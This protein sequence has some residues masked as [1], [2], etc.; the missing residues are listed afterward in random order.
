[1]G[2]T[3][4]GAGADDEGAEA[5]DAVA[6]G[7]LVMAT[8]RGIALFSG[9]GE[10]GAAAA[11]GVDTGVATATFPDEVAGIGAGTGAAMGGAGAAGRRS[12]ACTANRSAADFVRA[13][14]AAYTA[15]TAAELSARRLLATFLLDPV[16]DTCCQL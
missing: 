11:R 4:A 8:G 14:P 9:F 12:S 10:A 15:S 3:T 2:T 7:G 13:Y 5:G 16:S 6:S 1:M